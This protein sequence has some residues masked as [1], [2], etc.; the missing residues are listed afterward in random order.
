MVVVAEELAPILEKYNFQHN[1]DLSSAFLNLADVKTGI[2]GEINVT[3][4]KTAESK[5]FDRH[6]SGYTQSSAIAALIAKVLPE[7][8]IVIS[9]GTSGGFGKELNI[10]DVVCGSDAIF[11]D[12][13]RRSSKRAFDWGIFGG[14]LMETKIM[15]EKLQLKSGLV[16]SQIGYQITDWQV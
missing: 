15:N 7:T 11:M 6:Y 4:L 5:I 10:G 3:L 8:D 9:F 1:T 12:R 2:I 14:K 13:L 16:G